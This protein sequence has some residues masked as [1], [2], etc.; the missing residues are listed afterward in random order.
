EAD[1]VIHSAC[2]DIR[3]SMICP[4]E[5]SLVNVTGMVNLL[6]TCR[7]FNK[8]ILYISSVSVYSEASHYAISKLC[9]EYYAKFYRQ[10][11]PTYIVRLS[12][13]FG[14][15]DGAS[16]IGRWYEQDKITLIDPDHTR[17][18]TF[19]G[20]VVEGIK[21]VIRAK[22]LDTIDIGTGVETSLGELAK[23]FSRRTGKPIEMMP[24]REID[25]VEQRSVY[26]IEKMVKLIEFKP[27]P[28]LYEELDKCID[29]Y[30]WDP[31]K[32]Y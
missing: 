12:N 29:D 14:K 2:R 31:Q 6:S 13:V 18:F 32:E 5:D 30:L 24:K 25:N 27:K 20:D 10:W 4:V 9:G 21:R 19:I 8:P 7:K 23:W 28:N 15:G 17:D 1:F 16:V 22:P 26:E 3:N 11:I